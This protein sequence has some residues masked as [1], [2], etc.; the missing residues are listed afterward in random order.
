MRAP[1]AGHP[2]RPRHLFARVTGVL[3]VPNLLNDLLQVVAG[4]ILQRRERNVGF[5]L[6][7]AIADMCGVARDVRFGP[8]ADIPSEPFCGQ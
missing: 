5:E 8:L 4:R 7:P 1:I 2:R 3:H 6:L